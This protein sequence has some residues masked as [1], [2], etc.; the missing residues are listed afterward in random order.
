MKIGILGAGMIGGTLGRLWH[1]AGHE[2]I[3]GTRHPEKLAAL[4]GELG[5][6]ASAGGAE[7]AARVGEVVLLATPLVAVPQLGADLAAYLAGKVVLDSN[8]AYADRDGDSGHQAT[9]HAGGSSSWVASFFP[10]ARVVKAFNTV[11]FKVLEA[12]TGQGGDDGVGIPL[13][14]D[15]PGALAVAEQL[16]RD[17]G[18]TPVAIGGLAAGKRVEPGTPVYNTGMKAAALRKALAL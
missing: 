7:L 12:E 11:Y 9:A 3:F 5:D 17:A 4:V 10:G 2:V 8:N 14:S 16:V 15:D 1:R 18:F 6:R 13:A